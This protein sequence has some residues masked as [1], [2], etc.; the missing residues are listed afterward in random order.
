MVNQL[1]IAGTKPE[2]KIAATE[3][4]LKSVQLERYDFRSI[5][6]GPHLIVTARIH[7]DEP[8]GEFAARKLISE[9]I[10]DDNPLRLK[11]G[12]ITLFPVVNQPAAFLDRRGVTRDGNR[13][14]HKAILL[15]SGATLDPEAKINDAIAHEFRRQRLRNIL[16]FSQ[17]WHFI[18]LHDYPTPGG[19]PHVVVGQAKGDVQAAQSI[20]LDT[21]VTNWREAQTDQLNNVELKAIGRSRKDQERH[22]TTA[23][24]AA[25]QHGAASAICIESGS[26]ADTVGKSKAR[27]VAYEAFTQSRGRFGINRSAGAAQTYTGQDLYECRYS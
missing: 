1:Y 25:A 7:G 26:C 20:G 16:P 2:T 24:Y 15:P 8:S 13:H 4:Q 18:D 14:V 17:K 6:N 23:I 10:D 5:I 11:R 27:A 12:S 19:D 9:L 22:T 21:I 3:Q